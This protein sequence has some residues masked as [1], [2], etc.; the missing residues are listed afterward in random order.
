M[1]E[2]HDPA[3]CSKVEPDTNFQDVTGYSAHYCSPD[4]PANAQYLACSYWESGVRVFDIRDPYRPKEI[5]YYKAPA[6]GTANLPGSSRMSY[7]KGPRTTDW[8]TSDIRW[9]R[10]GDDL[11]LWF[12]TADNGF[13]IVKFTN[14]LAS[15]GKA[16][17]ET[18]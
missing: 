16:F 9:H 10:Q 6:T 11:Q 17:K 14:R 5:A 12:T 1:L 15:L 13:Q 7:W 8:A 3:N 2:V 4:N 18:P